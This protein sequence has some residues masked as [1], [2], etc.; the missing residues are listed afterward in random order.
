MRISG[1]ETIVILIGS[2]PPASIFIV[3]VVLRA[4][5]V[6]GHYGHH[7]V[8]TDGSRIRGTEVGGTDKGIHIVRRLLLRSHRCREHSKGDD[9][10]SY[11]SFHNTVRICSL[12]VSEHAAHAGVIACTLQCYCMPFA[13]AMQRLCNVAASA[14]QWHCNSFAVTLQK[15]CSIFA[16]ILH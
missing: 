7:S 5:H 12:L 8:G 15:A 4:H 14:L 11:Q 16:V 3:F 13:V 2:R 1:E 9:T 6:E 10:E